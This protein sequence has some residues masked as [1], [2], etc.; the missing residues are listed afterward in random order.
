MQ[1]DTSK[2]ETKM[3][4]SQIKSTY[5]AINE[6]KNISNLKYFEYVNQTKD[7]FT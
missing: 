7:L 3:K 5:E 2:K 6:F 1:E 4:L